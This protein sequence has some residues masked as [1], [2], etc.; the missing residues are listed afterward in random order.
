MLLINTGGQQTLGKH[1]LIEFILR[2]FIYVLYA[3]NVIIC[4]F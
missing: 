2:I 3:L 1:V 4:V